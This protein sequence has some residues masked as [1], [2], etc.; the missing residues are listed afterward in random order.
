LH[1]G[2]QSSD[3]GF[4]LIG[5]L[6]LHATTLRQA[7]QACHQFQTLFMDDAQ[8]KLSERAGTVQIR[9][10]LP[11]THSALDVGMAEFAVSGLMRL[12]RLFAG[13]N[14]QAEA[15]YFEHARPLHYLECSRVFGG[16]ERYRQPLTG[17]DFSSTL[18]DCSHLHSHPELHAVLHAQAERS[19]ERLSRPTTFAERLRPLFLAQDAQH[20]ADMRRIARELGMSVRSLRRRLT[21]EGA[22]FRELAQGALKERACQLLRDPRRSVQQAAHELGFADATAFHRAFKRWTGLT[23]LQF[24][25]SPR[26]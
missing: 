1:F 8:L 14:A 22:S 9:S 6:V 26:E 3:L 19:L 5:H 2:V 16:V 25:E 17:I 24:R 23:P 11:R 4:D 10:K 7:L 15:V 13:A 21:E 18:L 12:V 20:T